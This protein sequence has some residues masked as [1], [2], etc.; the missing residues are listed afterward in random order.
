MAPGELG[1]AGVP[2]TFAIRVLESVFE[3]EIDESVSAEV[4]TAIA[5]Q[6][7]HLAVDGIKPAERFRLVLNSAVASASPDARTIG[8]ASPQECPDTLASVL[9]VAAL[10]RLAGS[11][12]MFHAAGLARDDGGV[13]ALVGPSGRGKTTACRSLGHRLGYVSDETVAFRADLSV[14]PYPKPLSIGS[15]PG[16]KQL[17]APSELGLKPA[18]GDLR[19]AALV[20]LDRD[21]GA[22]PAVEPVRAIDALEDLVSQTSSLADLPRPLQTI[23]GVI[24]ATGGVRRMSYPDGHDLDA[25]ADRI[26]DVRGERED[27]EVARVPVSP[28]ELGEGAIGRAEVSDAVVLDGRL[29]VLAARRLHVLDG[30]GPTVWL[31]ADG[32]DA[33]TLRDRVLAEH[34][35]TPP[36]IDAGAAVAQAADQLIEA[37]LL[38][39]G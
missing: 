1:T 2:F 15:R 5:S 21:P 34:G 22:T 27:W 11:A 33:Q 7:A 26:P 6:W 23:L 3:V 37:G 39:R 24:N 9:T 18:R 32:V 4:R 16:M 14:I 17:H 30:I 29:V 8:V 10:R 19:L 25:L 38:R 31:Q 28:A 20:L 12:L 13:I 35:A 36:G